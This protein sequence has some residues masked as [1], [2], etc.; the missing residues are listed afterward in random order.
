MLL[1]F[2]SVAFFGKIQIAG[3]RRTT[4]ESDWIE[5]LF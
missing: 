3:I 4:E 1:D 2:L 5:H